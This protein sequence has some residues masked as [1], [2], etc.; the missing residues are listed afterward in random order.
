M[1]FLKNCFWQY[2]LLFPVYMY[3]TI[4]YVC[5]RLCIT[6]VWPFLH[7]TSYSVCEFFHIIAQMTVVTRRHA[8]N[9]LPTFTVAGV[10]IMWVS[11]STYV[12][13]SPNK[14]I[15]MIEIG[16]CCF[17]YMCALAE[18]P[19]NVLKCNNWQRTS[20]LWHSVWS[21]GYRLS[22]EWYCRPTK[23]ASIKYIGK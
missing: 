7:S 21:S 8:L 16:C 9:V 14:C 3:N 4:M 10:K 13:V 15:Q 20:V 6:Y 19:W 12:H 5:T 11:C 17:C 2:S 22:A 18:L 23:S 1:R